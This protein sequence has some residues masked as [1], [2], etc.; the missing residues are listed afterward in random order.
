MYRDYNLF[1]VTANPPWF[2]PVPDDEERMSAGFGSPLR[3]DG[4]ISRSKHNLRI[5]TGPHDMGDTAVDLWWADSQPEGVYDQEGFVSACDVGIPDG[6]LALIG[7]YHD[8]AEEHEWP[9]A[10]RC[11]VVVAARG[12]D[13]YVYPGPETQDRAIHLTGL[14][15]VGSRAKGV[16]RVAGPGWVGGLAGSVAVA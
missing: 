3:F 14:P 5:H 12:R 15:C 9:G 16:R 11:R 1:S 13:E 10:D 6:R 2:A 4:L 8:L 7:Y